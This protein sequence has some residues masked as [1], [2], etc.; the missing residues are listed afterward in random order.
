[1]YTK[2]LKSE[3]SHDYAQ[4]S[5][6]NYTFMNSA[7][8]SYIGLNEAKTI[9]I[10]C[11]SVPYKRMYYTGTVLYCGK[12]ALEK[13]YLRAIGKNSSVKSGE[14]SLVSS[15]VRTGS[16]LSSIFWASFLKSISYFF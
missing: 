2:N 6:R 4:K 5:Q 15:D 16:I 14:R 11:L 1:M 3:N 9:H 8:V 7:S 13:N 12:N 10:S